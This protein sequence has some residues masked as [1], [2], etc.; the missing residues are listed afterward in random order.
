MAAERANIFPRGQTFH[1][2]GTA[3]L[4]STYGTSVALEGRV[5]ISKA[6]AAEGDLTARD[7]ADIKSIIV[8]NTSGI[9][10]VP[11]DIVIWEAGYRR[12]R[13]N[14]K[15]KLTACE[16]AGVVDDLLPSA[17]VRDEDLFHLIVSGPCLA[18]LSATAAEAVITAGDL[19]YAVTAATSQAPEAGKFTKWA[20]TNSSTETE[21]GTVVKIARNAIGIAIS[22]ATTA[23]TGKTRLVDLQLRY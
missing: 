7:G 18:K 1:G 4:S 23:D 15:S 2:S 22:A 19:L 12:L 16:I 21:D 8:R 6:K 20:G 10:L 11:G 9:N 14:S 17:G 13:V 3:T 5:C